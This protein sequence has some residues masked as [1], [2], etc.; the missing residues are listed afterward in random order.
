MNKQEYLE[1]SQLMDHYCNQYYNY[2]NSVISDREYDEKFKLLEKYEAQHPE[3]VVEYSPTQ[4][5]GEAP[6]GGFQKVTRTTK[7]FSLDNSYS[8]EEVTSFI[9]KV[10]TEHGHRAFVVEPKID[11]TSIEI[12][13]KNGV[14]SQAITRGDGWTG[15]DITK[16]VKTIKCL[17]LI[18]SHTEDLVVRGEVYIDK[19]DLEAINE[20]RI[21]N[22]EQPFANPRNAASGSLRLLDPKEVANRPLKIFIFAMV[23]G[24]DHLQNQHSFLE[25]LYTQGLPVN[26]MSSVCN[27]ERYLLDQ[28]NVIDKK[29][30][31]LPYEIDGAV[32]KVD[33]FQ[34][35]EEIGYTSRAP[36][37]AIAYK[38]ETEKAETFVHDITIQV[39]RTGALTP[40]AELHPVEI[41]GS[42]VSRASLHNEDI[43]NDLGI[44]VGDTVI[45]EKAAEI[46][47]QVVAVKSHSP[48]SQPFVIPNVC[49]SCG[50]PTKRNPEEA[51]TFC[52]NMWGCP[53]QLLARI[54]HF[55]S[56]QNM[57]IDALG[58]AII[59]KLVE[60]GLIKDVADLYKL[61][62][63]DLVRLDRMGVSISTTIVN[64]IQ[65]SKEQSFDR[66]LSGLGIPLIGNT[67]SKKIAKKY[68][69]LYDLMMGLLEEENSVISKLDKIEGVGP[70][71]I[72]NLVNY[73][74][75]PHFGEI[76]EKLI[77]YGVGVKQTIFI[78][79]GGVL[80][81]KSFCVTGKLSKPREEI[82]EIIELNGGE[83][84]KSVKKSTAYL[85]AGENVGKTKTDKA[86]KY[87]C[88]VI[89]EQDL[90]EMMSR[91]AN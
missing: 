82:W 52:T 61:E 56:R 13:Y 87:G 18:I 20:V 60:S 49:P 17:P 43:I 76:V 10:V 68:T 74:K 25:W 30:K 34:V 33:N 46:I 53:A 69:T 4:R 58:P 24:P 2:N 44:R 3:D 41:S 8:E 16:N 71:A 59:E 63:S 72:R 14:F 91:E 84:H 36:K 23:K 79:E 57:D 73:M 47:P 55:V 86:K 5:I 19:A 42:V 75:D 15:E 28:V 48:G 77:D 35:Q 40:V 83:V 64:N 78:G 54:E 21:K 66:L 90:Y 62:I 89:S 32:I 65:S 70:K 6:S 67:V 27:S 9:D 45:V 81:D 26:L 22:G 39:G 88:E 1:L 85:V 7:M 51:R 12:H 37:W 80:K 38:F 50:E 11:G 29:R 31:K